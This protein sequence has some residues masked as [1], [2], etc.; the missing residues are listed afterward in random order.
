M[1]RFLFFSRKKIFYLLVPIDTNLF[2][3]KNKF[4]LRKKFGFKEKD[5]ILIYIG[6]IE[7]EQGSDYLLKLIKKNPD[8]KFILIGE[9]KDECFKKKFK[10]V[11]P[12][13]YVLHKD[14]PDYLNVSDL[15]LF[16]S[17]RN[18]YPLPPRESLSCGIPVILF[19]LHTFGQL[20]TKAVIKVPLNMEKIKEGIEN[21]FSLST[22]QKRQLSEEGREFIIRD[23]S[24][25]SVREKTLKLFLG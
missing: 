14:I 3:P 13:P 25:E 2:K 15:S 4:E 23:C 8:K 22:E 6:R 5:K 9:V 10:N 20:K 16:F 12:I 21:F 1:K 17:K 19:N 11:T 18:N 7:L 24:E